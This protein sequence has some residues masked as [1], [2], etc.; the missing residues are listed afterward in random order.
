MF[1][2]LSNAMTAEVIGKV[3]FTCTAR[4]WRQRRVVE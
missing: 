2:A 1:C 4:D 3:A